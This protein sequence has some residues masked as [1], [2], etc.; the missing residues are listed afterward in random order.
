MG[1]KNKRRCVPRRIGLSLARPGARARV[2][3]PGSAKRAP[4]SAKFF[5]SMSRNRRA[6]LG[7]NGENGNSSSGDPEEQRGKAVRRARQAQGQHWRKPLRSLTAPA[8]LRAVL[9]LLE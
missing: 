7:Q 3:A 2:R 1:R 9:A 5:L 6:D 8:P 4:E